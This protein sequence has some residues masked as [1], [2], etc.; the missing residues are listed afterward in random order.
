MDMIYYVF[1]FMDDFL[2]FCKFYL[3]YS[4]FFS[5]FIYL[6]QRLSEYVYFKSNPDYFHP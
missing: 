1:F 3:Y 6:A 4:I 5:I 2:I